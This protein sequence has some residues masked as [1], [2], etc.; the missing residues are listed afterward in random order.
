MTD[1][2]V[3]PDTNIIISSIFW[4]GAPYKLMK[5]GFKGDIELVI[6]PEIIEEVI[7]RL[8][9][10]F[11]TPQEKIEKTVD[12]LTTFCTVVNPSTRLDLVVVDPKDNKILEC[13]IAGKAKFVVSGD[14]HLLDIKNFKDV[15]IVHVKE[16]LDFFEYYGIVPAVDRKFFSCPDVQPFP[17]TLRN[18]NLA[19]RGNCG[20]F[21]FF[22]C[23]YHL[24]HL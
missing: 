4:R 13:A 7:D 12:L 5:R 11:D 9:N 1:I 16:F 20:K 22:F 23:I 17:Y 24:D 10:K 8:Q 19:L 6:S 21:H 14:R 15:K 3:V 2:R 18:Y